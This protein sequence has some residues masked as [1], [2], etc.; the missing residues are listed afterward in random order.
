MQDWPTGLVTLKALPHSAS[1]PGLR[2]HRTSTAAVM[3]CGLL[4]RRVLADKNCVVVSY[5]GNEISVP[6]PAAD[7]IFDLANQALTAGE[8]GK[9]Q[10]WR[11]ETDILKT[12]QT[13]CKQIPGNGREIVIL[14]VPVA[15]LHPLGRR[16][17]RLLRVGT[18]H[19]GILTLPALLG[20]LA[21]Y[22]P[23]IIGLSIAIA[24]LHATGS[25]KAHV[26]LPRTRA[27]RVC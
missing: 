25:D 9:I 18:S 26:V 13:C 23:E 1:R 16:L 10:Y 20:E 12:L 24:N 21:R 4:P 5:R 11:I 15:V 8:M 19:H 2:G 6:D 3:R 27:R 17:G 22:R 7:K 14:H